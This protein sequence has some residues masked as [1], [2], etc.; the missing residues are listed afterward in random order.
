MSAAK[1]ERTVKPTKKSRKVV[2]TMN[3]TTGELM[4]LDLAS[5]DLTATL[6]KMKGQDSSKL[7]LK[8]TF[9]D[10]IKFETPNQVLEGLYLGFERTGVNEED[11]E[12]DGSNARRQHMMAVFNEELG[13]TVKVRFNGT[14]ILS[15]ELEKAEVGQ[16]VRIIFLRN[17]KTDKGFKLKEFDVELGQKLAA[18]PSVAEA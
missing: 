13:E 15:N 17:G 14:R 4:T 10:F 2:E 1:T 12:D 18:P 5:R 3:E 8:K 11:E 6:A 16:Y 9:N 7:G